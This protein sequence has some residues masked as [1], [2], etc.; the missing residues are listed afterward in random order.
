MIVRWAFINLYLSELAPPGGGQWMIKEAHVGLSVPMAKWKDIVT[1]VTTM[2]CIQLDHQ[3]FCDTHLLFY[4]TFFIFYFFM[5][6]WNF[7]A[8]TRNFFQ[9]KGFQ[10]NLNTTIANKTHNQKQRTTKKSKPE[11]TKTITAKGIF[12][13]KQSAKFSLVFGNLPFPE[14]RD[15]ISQ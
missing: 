9:R 15:W 8:P 14:I 4:F 10:R 2:F 6:N 7:I 5:N 12:Q 3:D 11:N 1:S 13:F